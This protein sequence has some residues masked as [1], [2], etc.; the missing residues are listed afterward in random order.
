MISLVIPVYNAAALSG[1]LIDDIRRTALQD[2]EIIV[3]DDA[4]TDGSADAF[5]KQGGVQV[6]RLP[7]NRG[8]SYARNLGVDRSK[9]SVLF[10]LDADIRLPRGRDVLFEMNE[11]FE[12]HADVDCISTITEI[13]PLQVSAIAYNTSVYHAYYTDRI[14]DGSDSKQDRIMFFSTRLGG[15]R[16]EAFRES[17][18][19]FESLGA[20]MNEDGEFQTRCYHLG[21]QTYV[22][23]RLTN[24]HLYPTGFRRFVKAYW[25]AS[26]AQCF[27]DRKMDTTVDITISAAE[28]YRRLGALALLLSPSLLLFAPWYGVIALLVLESIVLVSSFGSMN[29]LVF[30]HVPASLWVQWYL[31]YVAITPFIIGGYAYGLCR[32]L[33]GERLFDG[34]PSALEFF[35]SPPATG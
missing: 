18:G 23:R 10:F 27:I 9:G 15:I 29:R 1:P 30:R 24:L 14:L 31:V 6:I 12:Q 21:Y 8:P 33:C 22:S 17:G 16:R 7:E 28:K 26:M 4:S 34:A 11:V 32:H 2:Y 3:V 19:F 25:R 35:D 13:E 20:N 5:E